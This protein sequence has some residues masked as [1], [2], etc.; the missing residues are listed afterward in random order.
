MEGQ[1][2]WKHVPDSRIK[3]VKGQDFVHFILWPQ[4]KFLK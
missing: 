3:A 2:D 1:W 4:Q